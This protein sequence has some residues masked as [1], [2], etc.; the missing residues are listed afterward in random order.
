VFLN[1][2]AYH[3]NISSED[4]LF[5]AF[6][7]SHILKS[8]SMKTDFNRFVGKSEINFGL[9]MT[10]YSIHPGDYGPN[11]DSS[12]VIE[13][14]LAKEHA[15]EGAL[16]FDDK[17]TLSDLLAVE[18]GI[19]VSGFHT[20]NPTTF[21]IGPEFRLAMNLRMSDQT[22]FKIN[23]NR[24][25]Q[26]LHLL[27]NSAAIAPTDIWKL[28]DVNLLPQIGDQFAAGYYKTFRKSH[29]EFSAELYFKNIRNL[30]DFKSGAN[31]VMN[32]NIEN[33]V[34]PV[35]GKA[36]GFELT[37]KKS[38]G[39]LRYNLGYTFSRIFQKSITAKTI[40]RIN[41]GKWFPANFD[42]PHDLVITSNYLISRRVSFSGN[43]TW[44]SGRPI[45]FPIASY[46][47]YDNHL[48]HYSDRNKYRIPDYSR[49]DLSFTLNGNLRSNKL[50]NPKWTFSFYNI[51]ARKNVY[52]I[53]FKKDGDV[54]KGYKLSVFGRAIPSIT[55]NFDF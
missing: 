47:I 34:V 38:E 3:Y 1:N 5:E 22:S 27:S 49:L 6:Q 8:T 23:Y 37:L 53:F 30:I 45:T 18:A 33:D 13:Q 51:L 7:L 16:Y 44:S 54:I 28:S 26:Y 9:D 11:G 12:L 35:K 43:F 4:N 36:Y 41:S 32:E 55:Y 14:S 21:Y 40:D 25:R 42:K 2:S 20:L 48:V 50:A 17:I 29:F 39:K 52:S 10:R 15:W 46:I 31:L 24:T 19:R